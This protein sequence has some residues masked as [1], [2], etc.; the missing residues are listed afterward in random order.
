MQYE[1]A[2]K[3]WGASKVGVE[4]WTQVSVDEGVEGGCGGG[5][6][7]GDYCYCDTAHA[8]VEICYPRQQGKGRAYTTI[9][10]N[11]GDLIMEVLEISNG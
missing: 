5:H 10:L 4:D 8:V 7:D 2:L 1:E 3:R 6:W 9:D 11:L